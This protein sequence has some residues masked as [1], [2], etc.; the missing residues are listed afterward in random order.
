[1]HISDPNPQSISRFYSLDILRGITALT[2]IFW[3]WQHFFAPLNP[4]GVALQQVRQ[5]F[6]LA[7]SFFYR[8]GYSAVQ[9]FFCLSGFVFFWLYGERV[10][11]QAISFKRFS[12]LRLSR[13]YPLHLATLL[14]VA[15]GQLAYY[16]MTQKQ[17]VYHAN[18]VYH[19][20]LNL[21]FISSWGFQ[22]DY[23]FNAPIWSVS[24]EI[25][26]YGVFFLV[27]RLL[28]AG[29]ITIVFGIVAGLPPATVCR[30]SRRGNGLLFSGR[31]GLPAV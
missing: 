25:F 20:V 21:L 9:L 11:S 28:K 17:F 10:A 6:F 23:S 30:C 13:L 24:V 15:A 2:V 18:D 19:F 12:L 4:T 26:L 7:L 5:P 16:A 14:L 29:W 27:C 1:M 3:H 22:H 31:H 8:H